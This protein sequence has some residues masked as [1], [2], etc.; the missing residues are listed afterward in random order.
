MI[1]FIPTDKE[2]ISQLREWIA[3]DPWHQNLN[4]PEWWLTGEGHLAF[5]VQ[6]D[7]GPTVYVKLEKEDGLFRLH[8]QFGPREE[9]NRKRLLESMSI[10]L[11]VLFNLLRQDGGVG[12]VFESRNRSLV[13]FMAAHGFKPC[14]KA[15]DYELKF[16]EV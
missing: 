13:A 9:V 15:G 1:K 6:D 5:C 3:K 14:E 12:V 2:D 10:G 8:C 16:S 4:Y 7:I 11:P